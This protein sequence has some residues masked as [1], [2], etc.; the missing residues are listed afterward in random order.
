MAPRTYGNWRQSRGF[1]LG[2]LGAGQTL[3]VFLAVLVPVLTL[4]FSP[5][6]ALGVAVV[7]LVTV[8]MVMVRIGG[9][10]LAD[11][12]LRRARFTRAHRQGWTE[13]FGGL[14][15]QHPRRHDLPGP[16]APLSLL[17]A[18]DGRGG[19]QGVLWDRRTGWLTVVIRISPVG[20]GLAD[21]S[22]AD[23]W[24]A[25]WGAFLADLGFQT[26][27]RHIAVTVD[28]APSGGSTLRDYVASRIEPSAPHA[29]RAVID[30][31]VADTPATSADVD[32]RIAI[33][34]DPARAT[35]RPTDL[36]GAV[37]EVTRWLP[38]LE[39]RLG[40]AG[41]A[42]L[43]RASAAWLTARLRMSYDPA[44]RDDVAALLAD[45]DP[46]EQADPELLL[47]WAEAGP[48]RATETWEHWRHDSGI[49]VSYAMTDAPRQAVTDRILTSLLA[50]GP[51]PRRV[52]LLYKAYSAAAAAD[53][54]EQQITDTTVRQAWAARTKRDVTQR[55]RDDIARAV[56][57][58]RE[59]AE[60]AGVGEFCLYAT[61]TVA[62]LELLPAA[63][64]DVEQRAGQSKLRLRR[65][66]GAQAGTFAAALGLGIDPVELAHRT[67][68]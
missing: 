16:M 63:T 2:G 12:L 45:H 48:V 59:E 68:R 44:S 31:L 64:A 33:T 5:P 17:S 62:D 8:V 1:G 51:F 47:A 26:I 22:Q 57:S 21:R 32:T 65:M 42:V 24:V 25:S 41:V 14:L 3:A 37:A 43:G 15:T 66:R 13:T 10:S 11:V 28:T 27:V 6:L 39:Q 7:S 54:V 50:P 40:R 23:S 18:D 35:P 19:K 38:G 52:T 55:D 60:G 9:Q 20:L 34:F 58:A 53:K 56:Q 67:R 46:Y 4:A 29:A 49:S 61:T 36:L 30:E